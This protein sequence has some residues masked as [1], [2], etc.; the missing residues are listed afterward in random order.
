MDDGYLQS[1]G[2]QLLETLIL[3]LRARQK[4]RT[5]HPKSLSLSFGAVKLLQ[6]KSEMARKRLAM[7]GEKELLIPKRGLQ[8]QA[9]LHE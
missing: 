6:A 3:P 5:C 7:P 8:D 2:S 1:L 9:A 4:H